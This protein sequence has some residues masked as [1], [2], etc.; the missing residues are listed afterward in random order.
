MSSQPI[1]NVPRFVCSSWGYLMVHRFRWHDRQLERSVHH[2]L[3]PQ[4]SDSC[5]T[6]GRSP[7]TEDS[8]DEEDD[9]GKTNYLLFI[10]V[11]KA[12]EGECINRGVGKPNEQPESGFATSAP[13]K[14]SR[15]LSL[16]FVWNETSHWNFINSSGVTCFGSQM[17]VV[18]LTFWEAS[19]QYVILSAK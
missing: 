17:H 14:D 16:D 4:I 2:R 3:R 6:R 11:D 8:P 9:E 7:N 10:I 19:S 18:V 5:T 15:V 12:R 1:W 13:L